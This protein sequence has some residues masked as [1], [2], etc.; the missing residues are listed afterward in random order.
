MYPLCS[1][2]DF[3]LRDSNVPLASSRVGV[4]IT[5]RTLRLGQPFLAI[6]AS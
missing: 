3:N 4:K 5:E 6:L 2:L 1:L